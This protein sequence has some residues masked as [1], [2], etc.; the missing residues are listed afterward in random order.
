MNKKA[1]EIGEILARYR[2]NFKEIKLRPLPENKK[3]LHK[4]ITDFFDK[5]IP[6]LAPLVKDSKSNK[7]GYR[8]SSYIFRDGILVEVL[9]PEQTQVVNLRY[10]NILILKDKAYYLLQA[11]K[12]SLGIE[13]S[14]NCDIEDGR[15]E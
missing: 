3:D 4:I 15:R 14:I 6:C 2:E 10:N 13:L 12:D 9:G 1:L 11:I 5:K 8:Y 7:S